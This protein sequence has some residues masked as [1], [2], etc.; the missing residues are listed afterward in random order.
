[1]EDFVICHGSPLDEDLYILSEREAWVSFQS[2]TADLA[3]FGH[4][5][6][7]C[8]FSLQK[9]ALEGW[10]VGLDYLHYRLK[11]GVRYLINPGSVGQPRDGNPK[12]AYCIYDSKHRTVSFFRVPYPVEP[13]QEAILQAGLPP[14][15]AQRLATG[16]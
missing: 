10:L 9:R 2:T 8:I 5:H 13:A 1:V 4:S 11:P 12:A 3:F 14:H 7:P 15:L 6:I 16:Q